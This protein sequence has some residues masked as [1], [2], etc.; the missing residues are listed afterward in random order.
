MYSL[1]SS[2]VGVGNGGANGF[3]LLGAFFGIALPNQPVL[4]PDSASVCGSQPLRA[5]MPA[6]SSRATTTTPMYSG[7]NFLLDIHTPRTQNEG[8]VAW[9]LGKLPE[10]AA[11]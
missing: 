1:L 10:E 11:A 9:D 6:T 7:I 5:K 8:A 2:G 3:Q 4:L